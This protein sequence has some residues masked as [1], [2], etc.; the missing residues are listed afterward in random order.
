MRSEQAPKEEERCRLQS[1]AFFVSSAL[2]AS[3]SRRPLQY[4][5]QH[6]AGTLAADFTFAHHTSRL[7]PRRCSVAHSRG[8]PEERS[9][10]SSQCCSVRP[11]SP[12]AAPVPHSSPEH[13]QPFHPHAP[14]TVCLSPLPLRKR[15]SLHCASCPP[16]PSLHLSTAP[17]AFSPVS[18]LP[19][20]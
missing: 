12:R 4:C 10:I 15:L 5:K 2:E 8:R 1:R 3:S 9:L 17:P 7:P 18:R 14:T 20:S 19:R 11:S 16:L 13:S 6:H